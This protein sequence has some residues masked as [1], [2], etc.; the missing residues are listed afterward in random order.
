MDPLVGE[1]MAIWDGSVI[2]S[3]MEYQSLQSGLVR[4]KVPSTG[5][6]EVLRPTVEKDILLDSDEKK[7][8]QF[9]TELKIEYN[10]RRY[11]RYK[12]YFGEILDDPC[13]DE[14]V[15]LA[16]IEVRYHPMVIDKMRSV[17][18]EVATDSRGKIVPKE[19]GGYLGG[20]PKQDQFGRWYTYVSHVEADSKY[21]GGTSM[22]FEYT[23]KMQH[24]MVSNI[25]SLGLYP[26]GFWHSHPTYQPFQSD[27]RL[28]SQYGNDVQTTYSI[29]TQW[30]EVA[31]VID[32]FASGSSSEDGDVA[33][34]NYKINGVFDDPKT[35]SEVGWRS[36]STGVIRIPSWRFLTESEV[37]RDEHSQEV[38]EWEK[39][40]YV[41]RAKSVLEGTKYS[42]VVD[43]PS[44]QYL[45]SRLDPLLKFG[46]K[47]TDDE[48]RTLLV[49]IR[50][51]KEF[52]IGVESSFQDDIEWTKPTKSD[53]SE[54]E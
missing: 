54:E 45:K 10:G 36:I 41:S 27:S 2:N 7:K 1:Q 37:G 25:V 8:Y 48:A 49:H 23:T 17:S 30:W 12:R 21:D 53:V 19:T 33:L 44:A 15:I 3:T 35:Y 52:G 6:F 11:Q 9:S 28:N 46:E 47:I 38:R 32:P 50:D 26:V 42:G 14:A 18:V 20:T 24:E 4:D 34:G 39:N 16:P 29:C 13:G 40:Y 22:T 5:G 31:A 43:T 51:E